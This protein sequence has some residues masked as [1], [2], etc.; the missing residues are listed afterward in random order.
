MAVIAHLRIPAESFELGRILSVEPGGTVELENMVPLGEKAVPFFSVSDDVRESFEDS[1]KNHPSV[2]TILEVTRHDSERLYSLDWNVGRD[3][4]F[5]GVLELDGQLLSATG[6][7]STWEFEIRFPTH[8]ALSEFQEYC[9]NAHI[10]LEVGRIYN[11]VRPGTGM[12]YGATQ[13]QRKTLMRAVQG[14][15]YS[16]PRQ[17]S[18]QELANELDISDQA[19]TERLRRAIVT[20]TENTLIAMQ[21][22]REEEFDQT[23]TD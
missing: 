15:Y 3:V 13:A 17:M 5:Q 21:D 16:I 19:V 4:F 23:H 18:T 22:E 12:W 9:S 1:V 2:G 10:T 6:T 7:A 8:E 20:L 11:P 14:G